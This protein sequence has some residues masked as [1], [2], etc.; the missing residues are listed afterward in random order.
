MQYVT[1]HPCPPVSHYVDHLWFF[2]GYMPPHTREKLLPNGVMELVIDLHDGPKRLHSQ[3]QRK[4]EHDYRG[5]WLS[6]MQTDF[7]VIGVV[8]GSS[9]MG[10]H[11]R[12]LGARAFFRLPMEELAG[13]VVT[14]EDLLGA[15]ARQ[16]RERLLETPAPEAKLRVLERFLALRLRGCDEDSRR[17]ERLVSHVIERL[18]RPGGPLLVEQLAAEA[19]VTRRHLVRLFHDQ[20]GMAPKTLAR[21]LRFQRV[22]ETVET[23]GAAAISWTDLAYDCGYYDQAHF[24]QDFRAFA[25]IKPSGYLIQR[26]DYRDWI[27][28]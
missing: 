21:I 20:V 22:I 11:F 9:M 6:G 13:K 7:L 1:H 27:V 12:T 25:G 23:R 10:A 3:G 15:E 8:R 2:E 19:G 17:S 5:A 18:R 16:L 14:L 28:D 26:G 4:L 24:A